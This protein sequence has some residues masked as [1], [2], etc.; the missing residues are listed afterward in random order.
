MKGWHEQLSKRL[1]AHRERALVRLAGPVS[2]LQ[3]QAAAEAPRTMTGLARIILV[4]LLCETPAD[5][6]VQRDAQST[7][8]W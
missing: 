7:E 8:A 5:G 3:D 6:L 1:F 4:R 2:C